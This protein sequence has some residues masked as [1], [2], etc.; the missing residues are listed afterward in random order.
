VGPR[1]LLDTV[2]KRKIPSPG[3]ESNPRTP[4]V[5]PIAQRYNF[6]KRALLHGVVVIVIIIHYLYSVPEMKQVG[7][8]D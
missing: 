7:V 8:H 1:A 6:S 4:I 2:M 5:Q 3:R